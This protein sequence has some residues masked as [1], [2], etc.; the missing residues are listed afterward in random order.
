MTNG[1]IA[2]FGAKKRGRPAKTSSNEPK[3]SAKDAN[4]TGTSDKNTPSKKKKSFRMSDMGEKVPLE[5]FLKVCF[6]QKSVNINGKMILT[7]V[8][9]K[10]HIFIPFIGADIFNWN[11]GR[12][13]IDIAE[14]MIKMWSVNPEDETL[15]SIRMKKAIADYAY[16]HAVL[17]EDVK[18]SDIKIELLAPLYT[19]KGF[20]K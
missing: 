15:L 18:E 2:P 12:V 19:I 16:A 17:I 3:Q 14:N 5:D 8:Y 6:S 4:E 20:L 11:M 10:D 7:G 13:E 9:F 1:V